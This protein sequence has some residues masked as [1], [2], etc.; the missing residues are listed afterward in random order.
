VLMLSFQAVRGLPRLR[1]PGIV[2][3]WVGY[4]AL[5]TF[6]IIALYKSTF[7]IPYHT[8]HC[9]NVQLMVS[10][11]GV[12]MVSRSTTVERYLKVVHPALVSSVQ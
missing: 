7:T 1:A 8:I 10:L 5:E 11:L 9:G 3:Y 12:P 6:V 4:S 2:P